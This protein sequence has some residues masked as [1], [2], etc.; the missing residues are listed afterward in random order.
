MNDEKEK[1][2]AEF[3]LL[4]N[5]S[6]SVLSEY[7]GLQKAMVELIKQV[8]DRDLLHKMHKN[9]VDTHAKFIQY[10][11]SLDNIMEL[12]TN[13]YKMFY[14]EEVEDKNE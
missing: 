3:K 6:S 14:L 2:I 8:K 13:G 10:T 5:E 1:R 4:L 7:I 9:N 11:K 12:A